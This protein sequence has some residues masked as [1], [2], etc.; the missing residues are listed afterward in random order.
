MS[1]YFKNG[2]N[3]L[4]RKPRTARQKVMPDNTIDALLDLIRGVFGEREFTAQE[5][6]DVA[7]IDGRNGRDKLVRLCDYGVLNRRFERRYFYCLVKKD[8]VIKWRKKDCGPLSD[9]DRD[10][11]ARVAAA[12]AMKRYNYLLSFDEFYSV[13]LMAVYRDW[14]ALDCA[15]DNPGA[16][17]VVILRNRAY[18]AC[19][20]FASRELRHFRN[21]RRRFL[22]LKWIGKRDVAALEIE[23]VKAAKRLAA[24]VADLVPEVGSPLER[25]CYLSALESGDNRVAERWQ[26]FSATLAA[27]LGKEIFGLMDEDLVDYVDDPEQVL[28]LTTPV[29]ELEKATGKTVQTWYCKR[30]WAR[31]NAFAKI[32]EECL[33]GDRAVPERALKNADLARELESALG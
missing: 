29:A 30:A 22:E 2:K 1:P 11:I 13:A 25:E 23:R 8:G 10:A 33:D 6:S 4:K 32:V 21:K 18:S 20:A 17:Q 19:S 3:V 28:A 5:F 31:K 24:Y 16:W 26:R 15:V 14:K 9:E 27:K 7:G 12:R